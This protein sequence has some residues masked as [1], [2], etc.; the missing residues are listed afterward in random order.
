MKSET[1]TPTTEP[2]G[3]NPGVNYFDILGLNSTWSPHGK[4]KMTLFDYLANI[5]AR[6]LM[7]NVPFEPIAVA[8]WV[9]YQVGSG[10]ERKHLHKLLKRHEHQME[11][12]GKDPNSIWPEF[13]SYASRLQQGKNDTTDEFFR[14]TQGN[15]PVK[16]FNKQ[17]NQLLTYSVPDFDEDIL[18]RMYQAKLSPKFA[19]DFVATRPE[20]LGD[21]MEI[22]VACERAANYMSGNSYRKP[23]QAK[24][25]GQRPY[26][27]KS[28]SKVTCYKCSKEGHILR[29]CPENKKTSSKN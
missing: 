9:S 29:N 3:S 4:D 14:L 28:G 18:V 12:M 11:T 23:H 8:R 7:L 27:P 15:L 21:A 19:R 1:E 5:E 2:E 24:P 17:F 16:E 22:A 6:I 13:T 26:A 25:A 10:P 20:T